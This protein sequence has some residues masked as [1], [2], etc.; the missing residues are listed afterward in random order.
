MATRLDLPDGQW[1]EIKD[2]DDLRVKDE[3]LIHTHSVD[4][5]SSDGQTYRFNVVKHQ[6]ATGAVRIRNWSLKD[7]AGKPVP[8]AVGKSF[9]ERVAAI[10]EIPRKVFELITRAINVHDGEAEAEAEAAAEGKKDQDVATSAG[11]TS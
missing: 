1:V 2:K 3:R 9:D 4:G 8:Y 5:V 7:K 11:A 6:I 10:E